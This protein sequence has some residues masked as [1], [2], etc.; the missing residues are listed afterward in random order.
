VRILVKVI[1]ANL[2]SEGESICLPFKY[3]QAARKMR[4]RLMLL[5]SEFH[6]IWN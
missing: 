6:T 4:C 2:E 3:L 1:G 5:G